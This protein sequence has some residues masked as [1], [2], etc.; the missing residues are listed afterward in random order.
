MIDDHDYRAYLQRELH[1]R[2]DKNP[3]YSLRAFARDLGVS[4]SKISGILSGSTG[5][6]AK[7]AL[8]IALHLRLSEHDQ[9]IFVSLVE[10]QH[11]RSKKRREVAAVKVFHLRALESAALLPRIYDK[12]EFWKYWLATLTADI[13]SFE[14][15]SAE[16]ARMLK[17][18]EQLLDRMYQF[19]EAHHWLRLNSDSTVDHGESYGKRRWLYNFWSEEDIANHNVIR[20]LLVQAVE[21]VEQKPEACALPIFGA[22]AIP[23]AAS[24]EFREMAN[25]FV[26]KLLKRFGGV[27]SSAKDVQIVSLITFPAFDL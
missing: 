6:S 19:L 1:R 14:R 18:D 7:A 26:D 16:S 9:Q 17:V 3:S 5:L 25:E 11:A 4:P 27:K 15:N 23:E 20:N 24:H 8:S 13:E 21:A 10:S 12:Q 2:Q 22:L